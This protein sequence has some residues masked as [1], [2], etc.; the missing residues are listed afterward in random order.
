MNERVYSA[1][2][3]VHTYIYVIDKP[4]PYFYS[5]DIHIYDFCNE[6]NPVSSQDLATRS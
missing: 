2:H 3:F 1:V 4:I 6:S 5:E